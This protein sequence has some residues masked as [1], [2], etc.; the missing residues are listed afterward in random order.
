LDKGGQV[1]TITFKEF[2]RKVAEAYPDVPV[3]FSSNGSQHM[4]RV[5]DG[6]VLY[7]NAGSDAIYGMMNGVSIGRA[8]GIE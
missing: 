5:G 7:M 2:K 1:R 4:A 8:I 3:F 6:L